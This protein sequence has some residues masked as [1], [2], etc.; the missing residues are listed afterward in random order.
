MPQAKFSRTLPEPSDAVELICS[1][2]GTAASDCSSGRTI[3]LFDL[4]RADAAVA[5]A[6][7]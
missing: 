3:E 4:L 5:D 2:P 1:R 6:H 7:A